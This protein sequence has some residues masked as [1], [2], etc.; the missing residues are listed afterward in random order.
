ML[1]GSEWAAENFVL[2]EICHPERSSCFAS[3]SR[4]GV[5]EPAPSE[6]EG[7]PMSLSGP[8]IFLREIAPKNPPDNIR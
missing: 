6:A 7:T 8:S 5:E 3:R 2:Y 1:G 4:R